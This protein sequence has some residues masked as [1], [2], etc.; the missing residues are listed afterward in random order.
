MK[1]LIGKN[2]KLA[3]IDNKLMG[4]ILY[5]LVAN[6]ESSFIFEYL[7]DILRENQDALYNGTVYRKLIID[8]SCLNI[9]SYNE[10]GDIDVNGN[11]YEI[12]DFLGS[13]ENFI[14]TGEYQSTSK[15]FKSCCDFEPTEYNGIEIIIEFECFNG[16]DIT[17]LMRKYINILKEEDDPETKNILIELQDAYNDYV[18]EQEVLAKVPNDYEIIYVDN[19]EVDYGGEFLRLI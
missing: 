3:S 11:Y 17:K 13:F 5:Q 19:K 7:D 6:N 14:N 16:L 8:R 4:Q 10:Q 12:E 15:S 9:K 2:V 18:S 1:R